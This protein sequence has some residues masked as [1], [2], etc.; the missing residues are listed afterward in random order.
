MVLWEIQG[1]FLG[2]LV[3]PATG[4]IA[5][6]KRQ[7]SVPPYNLRYFPCIRLLLLFYPQ[8]VSSPFMLPD[9]GLRMVS[10]GLLSS[11]MLGLISSFVLGLLSSFMLG[12]LSSALSASPFARPSWV[13]S[14]T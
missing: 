4:L 8:L 7:V 9:R 3:D 14:C 12:L 1:P 10:L 5:S 11:F 13:L 6:H 2:A